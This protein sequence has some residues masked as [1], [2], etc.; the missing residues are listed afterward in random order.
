MKK[1]KKRT[2]LMLSFRKSFSKVSI[3]S[4]T[5]GFRTRPS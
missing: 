2:R 1:K 4:L 5:K 3:T